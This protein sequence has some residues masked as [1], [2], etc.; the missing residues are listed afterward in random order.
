MSKSTLQKA[1][2]ALVF[3]AN[4]YNDGLCEAI[5]GGR[6]VA[7]VQFYPQDDFAHRFH[8]YTDFKTPI[9]EGYFATQAIA[10][11]HAAWRANV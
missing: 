9:N 6:N 5:L 8:L 2:V 11:K 4:K 3:K 7:A 1:K 10:E